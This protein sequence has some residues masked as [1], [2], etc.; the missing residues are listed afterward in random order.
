MTITELKQDLV[1]SERLLGR[2]LT[3]HTT[4]GLFSPK[5]I[6]DGT[7]LLLEY[8]EVTPTDRVLDLGC[9]Y[10]PLGLALATKATQGSVHLVDKDFIAIEYA[11]KNAQ[12]NGLTNT[13]AY[14]SNGFVSVPA[15]QKFDVVVSNLPAKIGGELLNIFLHDAHDRLAPG[16]RLYV[17]TISGLREYIKRHFLD[18]FGNYAKLKTSGTYTAAMAKR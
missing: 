17:V 12:L 8:M 16:G 9:G 4:W 13:R 7:K 14:L 18:V 5:A 3:F 10:G 11:S 6:D 2:E 15:D 1:F